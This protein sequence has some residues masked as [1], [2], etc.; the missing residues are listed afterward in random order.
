MTSALGYGSPTAYLSGLGGQ[1][2][3]AAKRAGAAVATGADAA[4]T[5][6]KSDFMRWLP[7]I[8]GALALLF[9]WNL[10]SGKPAATTEPVPV[11]KPAAAPSLPSAPVM[12]G[13]PSKVYFEVGS[14]AVGADGSKSI[15]VAAELIKKDNL[16]VAVTGYTDR[17]GDTAKNEELAKQ[18]A[19]A[20]RDALK[21][22]GVA[23]ASIE[24]RPPMFV[25]TGAAGSDA[26]ARRVEIGKK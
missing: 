5:T 7:W 10:F 1:T 3:D 23:E 19:A 17:T 6:A 8:I 18:R 11:A 26:E 16:Q 20:V 14:A 9:L 15:A 12:A 4:M 21:A 24:M 13:L 25:E 2:A 22:A